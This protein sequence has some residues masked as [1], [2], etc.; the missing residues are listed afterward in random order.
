MTRHTSAA[1]SS[2]ARTSYPPRLSTSAQSMS[3][4]WREVTSNFA[5]EED[6]VRLDRMHFRSP[7][8]GAEHS[9]AGSP[10]SRWG[11]LA[12]LARLQ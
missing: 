10:F 2:L 6:L 3:S 4:A 8:R 9:A 12:L 11:I 1:S 5:L 7:C